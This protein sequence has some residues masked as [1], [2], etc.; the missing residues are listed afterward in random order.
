MA[1]RRRSKRWWR[2]LVRQFDERCG[3]VTDS[4]F[5]AEVGVNVNT[6]RWW[7]CRFRREEPAPAEQTATTMQLVAVEVSGG[8]SEAGR[9]MAAPQWIEAETTLGIRV[10]FA[11][12]TGVGYMAELLRRLTVATNSIARGGAPC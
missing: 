1:A 9:G 3:A 7:R 12:G 10:R 5:A 2:R 8:E 4:V 6:L 11:E